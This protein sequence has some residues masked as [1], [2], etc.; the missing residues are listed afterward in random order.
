[1]NHVIHQDGKTVGITDGERVVEFQNYN[2][3]LDNRQKK[4]KTYGDK[5]KSNVNWTCQGCFNLNYASK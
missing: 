5:K 3:A 4:R 2:Y 1:M